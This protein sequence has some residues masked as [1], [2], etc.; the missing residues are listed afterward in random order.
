[1]DEEYKAYLQQKKDQQAAAAAA[2]TS[3]NTQPERTRRSIRTAAD[4]GDQK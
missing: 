4:G 2:K 3:Q 1:M